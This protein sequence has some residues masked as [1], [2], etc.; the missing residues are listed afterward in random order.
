MLM[1]LS[2]GVWIKSVLRLF[3]KLVFF[4]GELLRSYSFFAVNKLLSLSFY[5]RLQFMANPAPAN[6]RAIWH[7]NPTK[8]VNNFQPFHC[9]CLN[10]LYR[11]DSLR[12]IVCPICLRK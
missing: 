8:Q 3:I 5:F 6:N 1:K 2:L 11:K 4:P 9:N 10:Y 12:Q 7:I